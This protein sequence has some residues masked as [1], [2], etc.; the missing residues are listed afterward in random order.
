MIISAKIAYLKAFNEEQSVDFACDAAASK[1]KLTLLVGP[2]NSGKSSLLNIIDGVL[3]PDDRIFTA[4][5]EHRHGNNAPL[6][7]VN[8]AGKE[9]YLGDG[10]GAKF[11]AIGP[12]DDVG[13]K[14]K[15]V[16]SRRPWAETF[17]QAMNAGNYASNYRSG[18]K[19]AGWVDS[20]FGGA[21]GE[22]S[23]DLSQ[24]KSFTE[25][26]KR[27]DPD[28]QDWRPE[29]YA[30]QDFIEYQAKNGLWHR[31][32]DVGD[33]VGSVLRIC[34]ELLHLK[35]GETLLIDEPELSLHPQVQRRLAKELLQ[36]SFK[37]QIIVATHSPHFVSWNALKAGPK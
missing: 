29:N 33:G 6:V 18:R 34:F 37:A 3:H 35:D 19:H 26:L 23:T 16:P 7:K 28:I 24:K 13:G 30:N 1:S 11:K 36:K 10:S 14:V 22:L 25:L 5:K 8:L 17:S 2:N 20:Y 31:I 32:G 12:T 4:S 21:L 9:I 27:V 15:F